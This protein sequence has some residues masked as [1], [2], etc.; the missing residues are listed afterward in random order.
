MQAKAIEMEPETAEEHYRAYLRDRHYDTPIDREVRR[1]YRALAKGQTVIRALESIVAAG[2][3]DRG[4]PR[5]AIARADETR[6]RCRRLQD[7]AF[8]FVWRRGL[9][10]SRVFDF[11]PGSLPVV[12]EWWRH[13]HETIVPMIPLPLR[14]RRAL[15]GYH[16][17]FEAEWTRAVPVDPYLLKRLGR[18][19]TWLVV[20]AWDLTEVER[21]VLQSR[22]N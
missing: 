1:I 12:S 9:S 10:S 22:F 6:L 4:L 19:D 3:D 20:A 2:V 11:P 7:G 18:G 17:L 16:I 13:T 14:P 8:R 15:Q 21:A 5:L